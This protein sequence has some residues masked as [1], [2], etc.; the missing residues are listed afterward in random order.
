[1]GTEG[2]ISAAQ[3]DIHNHI[4]DAVADF[5]PFSLDGSFGPAG[6]FGDVQ[7]I[8]SHYAF[9]S[10]VGVGQDASPSTHITPSFSIFPNGINA[11]QPNGMGGADVEAG[12][13]AGGCIIPI[14]TGASLTSVKDTNVV[15]GG[16]KMKYDYTA[17]G[18]G[19][20]A[21]TGVCGPSSPAG[22]A[23][24]SCISSFDYADNSNTSVGPVAGHNCGASGASNA[25]ATCNPPANGMSVAV[26]GFPSGADNKDNG[27]F[28]VT[29]ILFDGQIK[30]RVAPTSS[31]I[32]INPAPAGVQISA[33]NGCSQ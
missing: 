27:G 9:N 31:T 20:G 26:T 19:T 8:R 30:V 3:D 15:N 14:Q 16:T 25:G 5:L 23:G 17:L 24:H 29:R 28:Q 33:N 7:F 18:F 22:F 12:G 13:D 6:G 1:L 2:L 10:A 32:T 11:D 4:N 21:L